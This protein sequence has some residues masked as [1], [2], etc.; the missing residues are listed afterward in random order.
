MEDFFVMEVRGSV[1]PW[2][3]FV[4]AVFLPSD[5]H[6]LANMEDM[7]DMEDFFNLNYPEKEKIIQQ[8]YLETGA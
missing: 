7:E 4:E 8:G 6:V 3:F 5:R 1:P 2:L